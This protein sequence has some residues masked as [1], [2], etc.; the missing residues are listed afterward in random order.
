MKR[1]H[2]ASAVFIALIGALAL[3]L[4]GCS[5]DVAP[6][7]PRAPTVSDA[8]PPSD[9]LGLDLG[10]LGE[11]VDGTVGLLGETVNGALSSLSLFGCET[12]TYGTVSRTVGQ[13]GGTIKVGPHSLYIPPGALEQ[14]VPITARATAGKQVRVE[15]EPHGLEFKR[16]AV[17][18]LSYAHC[19]S[20]PA[21]PKVVYVGDDL[22]ILE[23][24]PT[25]ND[26]W[27]ERVVGRLQH[28]SGYAF[29]D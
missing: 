4:S 28:F 17:L 3:G 23:T 19:A 24:V 12:P 13:Y 25:I 18:T 16:P 29:A 22:K 7:A 1:I 20:R 6:S 5:T 10:G 11:V 21:R 2:R 26:V 9:L 14:A 8:T 15:F 27:G